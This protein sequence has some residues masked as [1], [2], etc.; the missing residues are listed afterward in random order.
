M[1]LTIAIDSH[2]SQKKQR[3]LRLLN[4]HYFPTGRPIIISPAKDRWNWLNQTNPTVGDGS[5]V[6]FSLVEPNKP[7]YRPVPYSN[8]RLIQ[9]VPPRLLPGEESPCFNRYYYWTGFW[10]ISLRFVLGSLRLATSRLPPSGR[11]HTREKKSNCTFVQDIPG[12]QGPDH[13]MRQ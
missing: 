4:E 2:D 6:W 10:S 12:S 7:N 9:P 3:R 11:W 13:G 5:I 8:I 1:A